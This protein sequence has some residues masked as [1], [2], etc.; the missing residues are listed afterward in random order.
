LELQ[1]LAIDNQKKFKPLYRGLRK[2]ISKD[3]TLENKNE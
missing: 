1:L 2:I 3:D